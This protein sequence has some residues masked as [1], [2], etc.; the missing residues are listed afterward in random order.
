MRSIETH[1]VYTKLRRRDLAEG[2]RALSVGSVVYG[3]L[4]ARG[5]RLKGYEHELTAPEAARGEEGTRN[6]VHSER[7]ERVVQ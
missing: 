5:K 2:E 3:H 7:S 6:Q 4:V 1:F